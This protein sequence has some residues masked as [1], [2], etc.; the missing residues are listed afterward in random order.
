MNSITI[1]IFLAA[2][3]SIILHEISHGYVALKCGDPTAKNAGRLTLNP[4]PHIDPF[5]TILLP[6]VLAL[7]HLPAFGYAKPVPINYNRLRHP[8]NQ[9][10]YVSLV[11][12][13]V[14]IVLSFLAWVVC[15][16]Y[17]HAKFDLNSNIFTFFIY[18]GLVNIML[19]AF[20]LIPIPPLDGS[21]VIERLVPRKHL[22]RY[23]QFRAQALPF[24]F[25]ILMVLRF[26]P[27]GRSFLG[28]LQ[29]W[30]INSL[31]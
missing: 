13:L 25:V 22:G 4:I 24:A 18:F 7:S 11:G 8:R 23:L 27:V 20:N 30:W 5:G 12:P 1:I 9:S 19:A 26:T 10:V 15:E 16:I 3:P 28:N 6:V 14:N 31:V 21:A 2:V 29:Q 17:I